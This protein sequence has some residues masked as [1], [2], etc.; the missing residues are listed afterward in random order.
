MRK[1]EGES[2]VPVEVGYLFLDDCGLECMQ[3]GKF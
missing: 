3:E 2:C 1:E